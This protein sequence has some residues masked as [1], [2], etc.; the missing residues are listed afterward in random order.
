[1]RKLFSAPKPHCTSR[2]TRKEPP[3]TCDSEIIIY[4]SDEDEAFIVEVP[5]LAGCAA[6]GETYEEAVAK[7][8]LSLPS[9]SRRRRSWGGRFRNREAA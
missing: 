2:L 9:G 7:A 4:W 6:D 8:R 1:M 5:E 3:R